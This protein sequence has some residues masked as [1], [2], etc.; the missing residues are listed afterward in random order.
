[1]TIKYLQNMPHERYYQKYSP[2]K[3]KLFRVHFKYIS[4]FRQIRNNYLQNLQLIVQ[5]SILQLTVLQRS[6][7]GLSSIINYYPHLSVSYLL[8]FAF[9]SRVSDW[10]AMSLNLLYHP[11]VIYHWWVIVSKKCKFSSFLC[12]V[13]NLSQIHLLEEN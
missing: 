9:D 3:T 4:V 6:N 2:G 13:T 5:R 11:L 10:L 7:S 12:I 8:P 1:M